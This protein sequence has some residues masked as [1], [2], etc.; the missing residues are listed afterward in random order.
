LKAGSPAQTR[1]TAAAI[2]REKDGQSRPAFGKSVGDA[3]PANQK[4]VPAVRRAATILA[5]LAKHDEPLSL[6]H[7]ARAVEILPSTCL[8]ILREL[9]VSRLVTFDSSQKAYR[10]GPGLVELARAVLRQNS[11][12]D[13]SRPYLQEIAE[14]YDVTATASAMLDS[15]HMACVALAHPAAAMSLNVTLG[16]R[17]PAF[18]GAAGRCQAAFGNYSR[19]ELRNAFG[20]VRWQTPVRFEEWAD[21]LQQVKTLGYAVDDGDFALGVTSIATPVLGAAGVVCGTIGIGVITAQLE[22][23][24]REKIVAALKR[25]ADDIGEQL[26]GR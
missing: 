17:V 23:K 9:A 16:G 14:T 2:V 5:L 25:A 8:H 6:S 15:E 12:A 1:K 4:R 21:Q 11:F 3:M 26:Q 24:R 19:S 20:K 13:L 10:L 18:S 22:N 7:I